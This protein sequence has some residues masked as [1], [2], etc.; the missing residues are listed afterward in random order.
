MAGKLLEE[1]EKKKKSLCK[2]EAGMAT[3]NFQRWVVTQIWGR[4]RQGA[5]AP[6][7]WALSAR[8]DFWVLGRDIDLRSQLGLVLR[9]LR[10]RF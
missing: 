4:D 9:V 8:P 5:S 10:P 2:A 6:T 3:A 7:T 1:F